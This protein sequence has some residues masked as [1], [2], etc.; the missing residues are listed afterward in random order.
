MSG[1]KL[2]FFSG[3]WHL[4]ELQFPHKSS[5]TQIWSKTNVYLMPPVLTTSELGGWITTWQ[6]LYLEA[7]LLSVPLRAAVL[8]WPACGRRAMLPCFRYVWKPCLM[9]VFLLIAL[10]PPLHVNIQYAI[11]EGG[12]LCNKSSSATPAKEVSQLEMA[13]YLLKRDSPLLDSRWGR[14]N[15]STAGFSPIFIQ[16]SCRTNDLVNNK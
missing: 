2:C 4:T 9:P 3:I 6:L 11:C 15:S 1:F 14:H 5:L 12:R 13:I 10:R 16:L 8:A 7:G